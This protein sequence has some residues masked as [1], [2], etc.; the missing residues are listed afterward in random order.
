M[1]DPEQINNL[2]E[3]NEENLDAVFTSYN[4]NAKIDKMI[5]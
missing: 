5:L 2:R 4:A 1:P 3:K